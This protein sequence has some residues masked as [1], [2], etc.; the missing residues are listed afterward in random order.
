MSEKEE[1]LYEVIR[2]TIQHFAGWPDYMVRALTHRIVQ[3]L[4]PF[5]K[6]EPPVDHVHQGQKR[7]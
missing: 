7:G 6:K 5:L 1:E 2:E 4:W 3:N